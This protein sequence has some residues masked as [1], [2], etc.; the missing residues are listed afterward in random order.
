MTNEGTRLRRGAILLGDLYLLGQEDG[1]LV[2]GHGHDAVFG[3]VKHWD[4]RAPVTL[5]ADSP[6]LQAKRNRGF[7]EAVF[8]GKGSQL[9]LGLLAAQGVVVAGVDEQAVFFGVGQQVF[10]PLAGGG[11]LLGA[12]GQYHDAHFEPV[13]FGELIIALVVCRY[14]HDGTGSVFQQNVVGH[15][16]GDALSA[17]RIDG[18]VAGEGSV[19]VDGSGIAGFA[20]FLLFFDQG[21]YFL[22]Q[23]RVGLGKLLD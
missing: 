4:G 6:V 1:K 14:R 22:G 11:R 16:D 7:S 10:V 21:G 19:L 12:P 15:P 20:G 2:I 5:A 3:T 17:E 13:F 8:L 9:L 18:V 23:P